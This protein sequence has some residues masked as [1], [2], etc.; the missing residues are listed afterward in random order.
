MKDD[1]TYNRPDNK[2][3]VSTNGD[4][5]YVICNK[6]KQ[7]KQ[8]IK[9]MCTDTCVLEHYEQWDDE[10]DTKWILTFRILDE[11]EKKVELN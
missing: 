11:Y 9:R 2:V 3:M 10:E 5:I 6:E 8:V 4:L 1:I 7:Q